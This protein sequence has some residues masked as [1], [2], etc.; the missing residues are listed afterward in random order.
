MI[1]THAPR[2]GSDVI[3]TPNAFRTLHFNPRSP[4]G[5]RHVSLQPSGSP[6]L[7]QPTLPARG[8][9]AYRESPGFRHLISTHAP[10]TGSDHQGAERRCSMVE[11]QPTLPA[12]GATRDERKRQE[13]PTFQPTLPARGATN[14]EKEANGAIEFQPTL[15][16]RG[17]TRS[18]I[19]LCSPWVISTHAP[20]TGSD[21][22]A[23]L[24]GRNSNQFQPTLPARG[25]TGK[26]GSSKIHTKISTHAP[27][28]GS[29][30]SVG[31]RS[32]M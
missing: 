20:R 1:S 22:V 16:A 6:H 30:S 24:S 3:V 2:T 25:A 29:D 15:P 7:F 32:Q 10:R 13:Q 19:A 27:R 4:H 5:E 21:D 17:A 23:L 8:A 18:P 11:F 31:P 28:T 12:R 14:G 26:S 9:T